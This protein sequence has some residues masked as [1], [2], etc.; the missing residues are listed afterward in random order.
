MAIGMAG[1]VIVFLAALSVA[2][3]AGFEVGK[4]SANNSSP[5]KT[6]AQ[7]TTAS[8]SSGNSGQESSQLLIAKQIDACETTHQ[9]KSQ[10]Q[11]NVSSTG[12]LT[13]FAGCEWPPSAATNQDG[14]WD[15]KLTS[16]SGPNQSEASGS[17]VT[18]I[19]TPSCSTVKVTVSFG[20]QGTQSTLPPT[21]LHVGM[22]TSASALGQRWTGLTPYPYVTS[23]E[24][25]ILSNSSYGIT[26]AVCVG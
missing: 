25:G 6:Q 22:I 14:Y 11:T 13:T 26:D 9:L 7:G 20:L 15:V 4:Q 1:K 12:N 8:H 5:T 3:L 16:Q 24:I 10:F 2:S 23:N 21:T 17:N 18:Y 19:L